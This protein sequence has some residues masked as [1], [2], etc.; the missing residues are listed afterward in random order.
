MSIFLQ[1]TNV[2]DFWNFSMEDQ[3]SGK[4]LIECS[5]ENMEDGSTDSEVDS[6][7]QNSFQKWWR[8]CP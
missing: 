7:S 3:W 6:G 5:C 8:F 2:E 4:G 1:T